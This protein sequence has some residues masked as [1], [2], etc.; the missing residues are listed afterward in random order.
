[1]KDKKYEGKNLKRL[2]E[3]A[4][5]SQ[6]ALA[7]KI[8]CSI[9]SIANWEKGKFP[10]TVNLVALAEY[11]HVSTDYILDRS[12][13]KAPENDFIGSYTGLSDQAVKVLHFLSAGSQESHTENL[14]VL[15][16]ILETQFD[17]NTPGNI[18]SWVGFLTPGQM[19]FYKSA[20]SPALKN[21]DNLLHLMGKYLSIRKP[22][23]WEE[24]SVLKFEDGEKEEIQ[25]L[26]MQHYLNRITRSLSKLRE[27]KSFQ[28]W[29]EGHI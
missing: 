9:R 2:R 4:G 24:K 5:L 13:F 16:Y 15:N 29:K 18:L 19:D 8:G 27:E 20:E 23:E 3:E 14:E 17:L 25:E 6:E 12:E 28:E 11:F 10:D 22:E 1:M 7:D 26:R 21:T